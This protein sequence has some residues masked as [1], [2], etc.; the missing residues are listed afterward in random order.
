M[1][2]PTS[3]VIQ[4][5]PQRRLEVDWVVSNLRWLLLLTVLL[6]GFLDPS[7]GF[8]SP[9]SLPLSLLIG[10]A[11]ADNL[12][13]TLLLAVHR[14]P[15]LLS[16]LAL[17]VDTVLAVGLMAVSGGWIAPFCF[18]ACSLSSPRLSASPS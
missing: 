1:K 10:I 14:F 11:V 16:T 3:P 13:L 8:N 5:N 15:P 7:H 12:V 18:S 17:I 6:V 4:E 9:S 2:E